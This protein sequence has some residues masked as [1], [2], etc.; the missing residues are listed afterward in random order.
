VDGNLGTHLCRITC[1]GGGECLEKWG[2]V[3]TV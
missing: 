2:M 3:E 1:A